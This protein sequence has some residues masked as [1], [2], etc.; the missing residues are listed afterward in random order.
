MPPAAP[1][2]L[3]GR[4]A[5]GVAIELAA[6]EPDTHLACAGLRRCR[7]CGEVKPITTGFYT[8]GSGLPDGRCR[9]CRNARNVELARQRYATD[10]EF[11]ARRQRACRATYW[12]DPD[13]WRLK[14]QGRCQVKAAARPRRRPQPLRVAP[15]QREEL[16]GVVRRCRGACNKEL[17]V[18]AFSV[19]GR[20]YV[21]HLCRACR[22]ERR[23]AQYRPVHRNSRRVA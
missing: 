1:S 2:H 11:R 21:G 23:R 10:T 4:C 19:D 13:L 22:C 14:Q 20:G 6:L 12:A 9:P 8:S 17:P 16:S 5:C 3:V 7:A 18:V 15:H